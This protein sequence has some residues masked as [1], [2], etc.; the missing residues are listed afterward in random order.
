MIKQNINSQIIRKFIKKIK[1]TNVRLCS[2]FVFRWKIPEGKLE[3]FH[4]I[5][6]KEGNIHYA[7]KE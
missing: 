1:F 7:A 3:R 2:I 6:T 5:N 4:T